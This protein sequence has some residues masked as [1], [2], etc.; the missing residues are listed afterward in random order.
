MTPE[1]GRHPR[2][3][4]VL[5]WGLFARDPGQVSA[6]GVIRSS[7]LPADGM[8]I[9]FEA[10]PIENDQLIVRSGQCRDTN[11]VTPQHVSCDLSWINAETKDDDSSLR[12]PTQ[13]TYKIAVGRD[14]DE[15]CAA[16]YARILRSHASPFRRALF[17]SGNSSRTN[18]TS[19]GNR[20][21]SRR[22]FTSGY[23]T[24]RRQFA[25]ISVNGEEVIRF[26][27]KMVDQDLLFA[28]STGEPFQSF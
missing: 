21:S 9:G 8:P 11:R 12:E 28:R 23:F 1:I 27:L 16:V 6:M 15:S 26:E 19:R 3:S 5:R 4:P 13:Q 7:G 18:G 20:L 22:S 24:P 25:R 2:R 10:V 14:Q 17:D